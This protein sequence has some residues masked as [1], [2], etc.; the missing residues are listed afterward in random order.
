MQLQGRKGISEIIAIYF[1]A[2]LGIFRKNIK[3]MDEQNKGAENSETLNEKETIAVT[4]ISSNKTEMKEKSSDIQT[5]LSLGNE[6]DGNI[7]MDLVTF[8]EKGQQVRYLSFLIN[9]LDTNQ[10]P[11]SASLSLDEQSFNHIKEFFSQLEW[12]S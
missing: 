7:E 1:F 10:Q 6:R 5:Y 2:L 11:V 9:S 8:R 3:V 4:E 12:N